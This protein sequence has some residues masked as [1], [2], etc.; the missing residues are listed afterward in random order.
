MQY[1]SKEVYEYIC[2]KCDDS[3]IKWKE[4]CISGQEFPIYKSDLEFYNKVSPTFEVSERYAKDF[5]EKNSD[6]NDNF[7]YKN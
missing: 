2:E 7:E 6:V 5:L 4:C 1:T 3:I